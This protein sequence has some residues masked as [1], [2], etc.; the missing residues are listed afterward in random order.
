MLMTCYGLGL[1]RSEVLD[2]RINDI[3]GG[4]RLVHIKNAKGNKD[5]IVPISEKLLV[6]LREYYSAYKPR[7]YLFY[8]IK[9]DRYSETSFRNVFTQA[10]KRANIRKNVTIHSLR[11]AYATHLMDNGTDIR[12]IQELLGHNSIKT[13]MQYTHVTTRSIQ[14]VRNPLDD[15]G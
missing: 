9:H 1:R 5:R 12:L 11:H 13:T 8:G 10:C 4:R 15:W 3:D 14:N 6:L 7:G 2:L